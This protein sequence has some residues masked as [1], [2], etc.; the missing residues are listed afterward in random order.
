LEA[1]FTGELLIAEDLPDLDREELFR[2]LPE[3]R[4]IEDDELREQVIDVFLNHCPSYYWTCPASSSGNHHPPDTRG[5]HGLLIHSK[6]AFWAFEDLSR[7]E[8]EMGLIDEEEL[9]YGRA[10]I[11][12]HDLFKQGLPPRDEHHTVQDHDKIAARHLGRK[13]DLPDEVL[14]C[15]DSHN[16]AWGEGKE[17]ETELERLHHR[18][19]Y[20]VSRKKCHYTIPDP[21]EELQKVIHERKTEEEEKVLD[22]CL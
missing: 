9:D 18:A 22:R 6:R 4:E 12:L 14:G 15:I 19:D 1:A 5:K 11:L 20:I 21:C 8:E 3:I 17:P 13:T 10:G 16:G 7:T 2:R